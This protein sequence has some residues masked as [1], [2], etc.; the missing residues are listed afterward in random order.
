MKSSKLMKERVRRV[1]V[2]MKELGYD[3]EPEEI[4]EDGYGASVFLGDDYQFGITL[5]VQSKYLEIG[6]TFGFSKSFQERIRRSMEEIMGICYEHG[7]YYTLAFD[8]EEIIVSLF[9]KIYFAG[10]NYYAL[11]ETIRDLI[12]AIHLVSE[13]FDVVAQIQGELD[14]GN[15]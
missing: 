7:C 15:P 13:L 12:S 4:A 5:D 8:N 6:Y 2:L 14:Y 1:E 9:S 3:L 10:M 11:K